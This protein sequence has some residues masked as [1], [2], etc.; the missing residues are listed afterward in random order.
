MQLFPV[1]GIHA[2]SHLHT[3]DAIYNVQFSATGRNKERIKNKE[4]DVKK[5][6][7]APLPSNNFSFLAF[8]SDA[9]AQAGG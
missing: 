7:R 8:F 9:E 1:A 2:H 3:P 5:E 4:K 6:L